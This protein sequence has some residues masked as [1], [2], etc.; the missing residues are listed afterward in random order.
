[1]QSAGIKSKPNRSSLQITKK[2]GRSYAADDN[3]VTLSCYK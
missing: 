3:P 1:M 2:T